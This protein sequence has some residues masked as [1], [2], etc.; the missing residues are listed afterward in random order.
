MMVTIGLCRSSEISE[1]G[2][3]YDSDLQVS[4]IIILCKGGKKIQGVVI[5]QKVSKIK[6]AKK[7]VKSDNR[8]NVASIVFTSFIAI[9]YYIL[10]YHEASDFHAGYVNPSCV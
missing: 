9:K 5:A 8:I 7:T 10:T 1:Q 6:M 2:D 3:R 4:G